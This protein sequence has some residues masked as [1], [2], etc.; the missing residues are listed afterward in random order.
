MYAKIRKIARNIEAD[1]VKRFSASGQ[2]PLWVTEPLSKED[3]DYLEAW[4]KL[5]LKSMA[6]QR[7]AFVPIADNLLSKQKLEQWYNSVYRQLSSVAH[8]DRFAVE[9]VSPR[10]SEEGKVVMALQAHWPKLLV[11]YTTLLDIIQCYEATAVRFG[12]DASIKFESLFM[13]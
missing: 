12:Q 9:M 2:L 13:E 3:K 4:D 10:P 6:A 7:D 8:Y 1:T 5:D 11:L